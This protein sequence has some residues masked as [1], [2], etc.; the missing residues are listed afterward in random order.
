S[1]AGIIVGTGDGVEVLRA[2]AREYGIEDRIVLTGWIPHQDL[3]A[4]I[5]VIDICLSTQ[6]ND[7]VG[8]VR[9][10]A[11]LPQYLACGRYVIASDVGGAREFVQDAGALIPAGETIDVA[12]L[13]R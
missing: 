5:N 13:D 11:K 12:Y 4:Y 10:T 6:T 8:T 9:L 2:L 3:P 7:L 1:V